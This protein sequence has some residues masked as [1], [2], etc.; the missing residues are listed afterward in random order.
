MGARDRSANGHGGLAGVRRSRP[1]L[2]AISAD[3]ISYT[4]TWTESDVE[5]SDEA[6]TYITV[7]PAEMEDVPDIVGLLG[8]YAGQGLLRIRGAR[9]IHRVIGAVC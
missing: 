4:I 9:E 7:R 1:A 3:A 2:V 6:R 5:A 8:Q